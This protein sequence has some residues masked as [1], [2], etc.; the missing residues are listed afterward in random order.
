VAAVAPVP[1]VPT[2]APSA[3]LRSGAPQRGQ[4]RNHQHRAGR[5]SCDRQLCNWGKPGR[6]RIRIGPEDPVRPAGH[7]RPLETTT[8]KTEWV[9]RNATSS[10]GE[11]RS[12]FTG[13]ESAAGRLLRD[14]AGQ[15]R[16]GQGGTSVVGEEEDA[17]GGW[18]RQIRAWGNWIRPHRRRMRR[19]PTPS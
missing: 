12:T 11:V 16:G 18:R 15:R 17:R 7:L 9:L 1:K 13:A 4:G 19:R 14:S 3:L 8:K 5:R 2:T 10:R 6:A